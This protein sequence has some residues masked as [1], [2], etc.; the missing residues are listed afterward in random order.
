MARGG[1]GGRRRLRG[2]EVARR[3]G[4]MLLRIPLQRGRIRQFGFRLRRQRLCRQRLR[5][6]G[7]RTQRL[8]QGL[9]RRPTGRLVVD[10]GRRRGRLRRCGRGAN[11]AQIAF[12]RRQ[13]IDHVAERAVNGF[14][15]VLRAAVGFRLAEADVGQFALDEVDD[16][17]IHRLR[18]LDVAAA[19]GERDQ[20]GVLAFERTQDVVQALLD[21]PEIDRRRGGAVGGFEAFQ[22][23][24]DALFEMG[25]RRRIVVADRDAVEPLRQRAQRAFQIFRVGRLRRAVAGSPASRSARR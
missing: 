7:L 8:H 12:D 22:Q 17:G 2:V 16:A 4:E 25:K 5:R 1:I 10:L 3:G 24:G 15:R 19:V 13:A 23:I 6:Q 14:E 21:P 9:Q 11:G 18:R 20:A